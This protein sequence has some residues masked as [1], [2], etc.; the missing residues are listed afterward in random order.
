MVYIAVCW[1]G[2]LMTSEWEFLSLHNLAVALD[3]Q[4]P[5]TQDHI[6]ANILLGIN[7]GVCVYNFHRAIISDPG[8]TESDLT[9][10]QL[11]EVSNELSIWSLVASS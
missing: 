11:S 4:F 7:F 3:M 8:Y 2:L 9:E 5:D 10:D 6:W 1:L